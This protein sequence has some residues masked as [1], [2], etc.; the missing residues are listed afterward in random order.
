MAVR[1]SSTFLQRIRFLVRRLEFL[2]KRK[3]GS[4]DTV[5]QAA[6]FAAIQLVSS[7]KE[8]SCKHCKE[9]IIEAQHLTNRFVSGRPPDIPKLPIRKGKR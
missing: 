9:K 2:R 3:G 1:G 7:L 6:L 8:C 4:Y 5:E